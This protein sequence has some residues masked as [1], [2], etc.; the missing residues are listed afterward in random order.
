MDEI[1]KIKFSLTPE[2][3]EKIIKINNL[4]TKLRELNKD[5]DKKL[6]EEE[7]E[8][9]KRNFISEFQKN[10]KKQISTYLKLKEIK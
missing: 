4:K 6:L 3:A 1:S 9:E 5:E 8:K 2:M 10:N 7:I